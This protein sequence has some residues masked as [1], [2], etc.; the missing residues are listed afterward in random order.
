VRKNPL[1]NRWMIFSLLAVVLIFAGVFYY[2]RT[3]PATKENVVQTSTIGT[4]NIILSATGLGTLIPSNEV[5]FGFKQS[6]QV[7]EVLAA[8]GEKVEAGQVLARLDSSTLELQYKQAEG[9]VAAL[10]S[11]A[12]STTY[13]SPRSTPTAGSATC[14]PGR[15]TGGCGR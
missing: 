1:K 5:S 3:K 9:N 15:P 7:S 14:C 10:S 8:L 2:Y 11:P 4:G 13:R 12:R 6:G